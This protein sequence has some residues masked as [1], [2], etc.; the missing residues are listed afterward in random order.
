[1]L[2]VCY[3]LQSLK[4]QILFIYLIL[5]FK[6]LLFTNFILDLYFSRNTTKEVTDRLTKL[7]QHCLASSVA[8]QLFIARIRRSV[9]IW[10]LFL[11]WF[12]KYH[13]NILYLQQVN[14]FNKITSKYVYDT[15]IKYIIN[16]SIFQA[17]G[18]S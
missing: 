13:Y 6:C 10:I 16:V 11:Q 2:N 14:K 7:L 17:K 12:R 3:P 9:L 5:H 8:A 15:F 1:M 18:H 4:I